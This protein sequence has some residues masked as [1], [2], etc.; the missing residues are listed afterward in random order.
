M[1]GIPPQPARAA[2]LIAAMAMAVLLCGPEPP[3]AAG[4]G[5]LGSPDTVI[6]VGPEAGSRIK[7]NRPRFEFN[8]VGAS[9]DRASFECRL[10]QSEF[11]ACASPLTLGPLRDGRHRLAVRGV[12]SSGVRDPTPAFR[13][14]VVDT[15]PPRTKIK[16]GPHGTLHTLRRRL[17]STFRFGANERARHR[18][19][20][21]AH[22]WKHCR[23]PL[24]IVARPGRHRLAVR[25]TD[26][27]GNSDPTPLV[28]RWRVQ[29]WEPDFPAARRY[30]AL[31][32]GP[33]SFAVDVGWRAYQSAGSRS[34]PMA[35]TVKVMLMAAYLHKR[36]EDRLNGSEKSLL[37]AMIRRSDN[38]AA[39]VIRD[40]VGGQAI[41]RL[42]RRAGMR[43]FRYS[44]AWGLCRT[45]ARDQAGFMRR[46]DASIPA[47]HEAFAHRQLRHVIAAQRWGTAVVRTPGWKLEFK[48]GWGIR[49]GGYGGTVNH[50]VALLRR[51]GAKIGVAILTQGN[52]SHSYGVATLE[53][54]AKR[55]LG[56]LPRSITEPR[57]AD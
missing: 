17:P 28:R 31:R 53:G 33:I 45:S 47:G 49:D 37:S 22:R 18:C 7:T 29:R 32:T 19:R 39:T 42:A 51:H 4:N 40:R 38:G 6:V 27:A 25:A 46:L 50:Q 23:S 20:I 57:R 44:S 43:D 26:L 30:A 2:L 1:T 55:L 56:G 3:T 10:D 5:S 35:S 24:T 16:R 13:G 9:A 12:D 41:K 21:D 48:G 34:A 11:R 15:R 54:I 8:L 36:R 14:F 52:P